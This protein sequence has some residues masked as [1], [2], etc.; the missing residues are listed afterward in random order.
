MH[1]LLE[2]I[3][4]GLR[5][6]L[7]TPGATL[8]AVLA[9]SLGIGA[10]TSVFSVINAVLLRPLPYKDPD[11]LVAV[12]GNQ[13]QK[14]LHQLHLSPLDYRDLAG[15]NRAFEQIGAF[16][17]QTSVL[18]GRDLPEQVESAAVSPE[19]F[20]MLGAKIALGRVFA[21]DEDRADKN[22]VA[23]FSDGF[24]RRRFGGDPRV[25]GSTVTLD[26]KNYAV[27]G[28]CCA[29]LRV[30]GQRFRDLDPLHT[31]PSRSC[32]VKTRLPLSHRDRAP[33]TGGVQ[34]ASRDRN[35][36]HR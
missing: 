8:A 11:R 7:K 33:E 10:N 14:G 4:Y 35:A 2:D 3:R 36:G 29:G 34:P 17:S 20:Q 28:V 25:L 27:I 24:W 9:L 18:T 22:S 15:G 5:T 26:G 13:P 32:S 12:W 31:Q 21:P 16:R 30:A 19:I 1:Q 23:V 6:L